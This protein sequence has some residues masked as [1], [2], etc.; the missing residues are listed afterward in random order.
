MR[1]KLL[2]IRLG[3][4]PVL[5]LMFSTAPAL[6]LDF[7]VTDAS[8]N[9]EADGEIDMTVSGGEAPYTYTWIGPGGFTAYTEDLTG[10]R[11][12]QY[13]VTVADQDGC[14][15]SDNVT[16]GIENEIIVSVSGGGITVF[17]RRDGP[18]EVTLTASAS[19]GSP[20][21]DYSWPNGQTTVT[22]TGFYTVTVTDSTGCFERATVF[23]WFVSV[24]CSSDPNDIIG[25]PGYG[26]AQWVSINDVLP[27]T[28]RFE[29]DPDVATAPAQVVSVIFPIDSTLNIYSLRLSDFGFGDFI[30][31]VPPNS[32]F[33]S[34]RLDVTDSLGVFVDITAGIDVT[35]HEA[36]W[37]FESI[38]PLTGLP[39]ADPLKGFLLVNDSITKRGEGFVSFAIQPASTALTGDTIHA[40]ADIVFDLNPAILTPE[41]FNVVDAFPPATSVDPLPA[42]TD[43][44]L[45]DICW[46]GQDDVGGCGLAFVDLYMSVNGGPYQLYQGNITDTCFTVFGQLGNGYAFYTLGTDHVGNQEQ[47]PASPDATTTTPDPSLFPVVILGISAEAFDTNILVKW[48][49]ASEV[50]ADQFEL[51]RKY[52]VYP[53]TP[54]A[55]LDAVGGP[56][57]ITEYVYDDM[58]VVPLTRY[59]YRVKMIDLDG[60]FLY[61]DIVE[62]TIGLESGLLIGEFYPNPT[63]DISSL[64]IVMKEGSNMSVRV[65]NLQGQQLQSYYYD[66]QPGYNRLEVNLDGYTRGVYYIAINIEGQ[67]YSRKVV[68]F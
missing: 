11:A 44:A 25:P 45:I 40:I 43:S 49:T 7:V 65:F 9:S 12:G 53:W 3:L 64:D 36:F 62:A 42:V 54:A 28:I 41:I 30:F 31:Q 34:Q 58:D 47:P 55:T 23:V 60:S 52:D 35:K 8:C 29:N 26:D 20:P 27:Y 68:K 22:S 67:S 51:Q 10:L 24:R 66:L 19:G 21:Y 61:S 15:V 4:L 14:E 63:T 16:V 33:Y 5:F 46:T 56:N 48:S 50:N 57:Q 39:P 59:F 38:D 13:S 17:C 6:A 18:P 2:H 32:T 1:N 37:I